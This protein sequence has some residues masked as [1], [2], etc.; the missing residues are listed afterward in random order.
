M[1]AVVSVATF[2]K[3]FMRSS[4]SMATLKRTIKNSQI[5]LNGALSA[6]AEQTEINRIQ[7]AANAL[8]KRGAFSD[9]VHASAKRTE[10]KK[11]SDIRP[12]LRKHQTALAVG[13]VALL[14]VGALVV[15][16]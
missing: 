10:L 4:V 8:E 6:N 7:G 16:S 2:E 1:A 12:F 11:R 15:K 14:L 13:G 9:K 5:R 3:V